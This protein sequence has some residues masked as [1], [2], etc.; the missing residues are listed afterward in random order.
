MDT[1]FV[2][3]NIKCD[4]YN[5]NMLRTGILNAINSYYDGFEYS[6]YPKLEQTTF[7]LYFM[8]VPKKLLTSD[9]LHALF[10]MGINFKFV[11]KNN[12]NLRLIDFG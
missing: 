1:H 6:I 7:N 2:L 3:Y 9:L 10:L 4:E 11:D 12:T 5:I 8:Y